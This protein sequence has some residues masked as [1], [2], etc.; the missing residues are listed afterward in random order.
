MENVICGGCGQSSKV[1]DNFTA[2]RGRCPRCGEIVLN[3]LGE[4]CKKNM[5]H[6]RDDYAFLKRFVE[7][8]YDELTLFLL[9]SALLITALANV[10]IIAKFIKTNFKGILWIFLLYPF[11]LISLAGLI[12]SLYHVFTK[13]LKSINEITA[14]FFFA[15]ITNAASGIISAFYIYFDYVWRDKWYLGIF[16]IWVL[17]NSIFLLIKLF[18]LNEKYDAIIEENATPAQVISALAVL[19]IIFGIC[20]FVFKLNWAI[21][22]SISV[23]YATGFSRTFRELFPNKASTPGV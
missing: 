8:R 16:S 1:P 18:G 23:A 5:E 4:L 6:M 10:G 20:H 22:L 19:L 7:I 14:M 11:V 21:T 17:L 12:L 13:R 9:S 3:L 2:P 15:L